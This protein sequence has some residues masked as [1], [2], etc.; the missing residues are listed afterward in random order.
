V[1]ALRLLGALLLTAAG[2]GGG[3]AGARRRQRECEQAARFGNLLAYLGQLLAYQA[4]PGTVL[5]ARALQFTGA[6]GTALAHCTTLAELPV[7]A[8]LPS[9]LQNEL[10]SELAALETLPR[11]AASDALQRLAGLCR[12]QAGTMQ[13]AADEAKRLWPR[14]G[15]CAGLLAA[16]MLW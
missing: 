10:H 14:L 3:W 5:L 11:T 1:T 16:I 12:T 7:P 2:M 15:A 4:L 13:A 9:P 8:C 6:D